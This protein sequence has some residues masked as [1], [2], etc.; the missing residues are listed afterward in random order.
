MPCNTNVFRIARLLGA[1]SVALF[2]AMPVLLTTGSALA[3]PAAGRTV[4][5]DPALEAAERAF[6]AMDEAARRATLEA[7]MWTGD[8]NGVVGV[9]F[10]R[11][12]YSGIRGWQKK[13]NLPQT[14]ILDDAQ[15]QMLLVEGKRAHDA[16]RFA[17]L[18]ERNAGIRIGAPAR[19]TEKAE[20]IDGPVKGMRYRSNDGAMQL[21]TVSWSAATLPLEQ[22]FTAELQPKPN[23]KVTYKLQRP[24]FVVVTGEENGRAFY[25]RAALGNGQVRG[26]TFS[27]PATRKG[28]FDRVMLAIANS[29]DPFPVAGAAIA[30]RPAVTQPSQTAGQQGITV[31]PIPAQPAR[32]RLAGTGIVTAPGRVLTSAAVLRA[33]CPLTVRG[34]P[35]QAP[36]AADGALTVLQVSGLA[37]PAIRLEHSQSPPQTGEALLALGAD[38]T[39]IAVVSGSGVGDTE[40]RQFRF[41]GGLGEG[42]AGAPVF[43][44][45]GALVGIVQDAPKAVAVASLAP[46]LAPVLAPAPAARSH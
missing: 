32:P 7:L 14:G 43:N 23:R 31:R 4:A 29:F 45:A 28:D 34:L 41:I 19:V 36:P 1:A 44:S 26:F 40:S 3:Q 39:G 18:D 17:V 42:A 11:L 24:D 16:V 10:G 8:Y 5:P 33:G 9:N 15:R 25:T 2:A 38:R 30:G 37:A 21:E 13:K 27:Y 22:F 20:K 12:G 35:A 46:V 6:M